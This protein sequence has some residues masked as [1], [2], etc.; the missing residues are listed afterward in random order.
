MNVTAYLKKQFSNLNSVIH[1]YADD[2][3]DE[4]WVTRPAAGENA[5]TAA[6][7][8]KLQERTIALLLVL[9]Q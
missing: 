6:P 4:E 7:A 8:C 1:Y 9:Q 3:T 5:P 2:L